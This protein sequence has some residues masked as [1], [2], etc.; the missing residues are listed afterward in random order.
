MQGLNRTCQNETLDKLL[1]QFL[2]F[3]LQT[4]SSHNLD[5]NPDSEIARSEHTH[6]HNASDL[7][8]LC[9]PVGDHNALPTF[10]LE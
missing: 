10:C 9:S 7:P 4:F 6:T 5:V 3:H 1:R 2:E 8:D